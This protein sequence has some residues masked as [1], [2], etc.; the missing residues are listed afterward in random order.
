[1]TT[2]QLLQRLLRNTTQPEMSNA[3]MDLLLAC[4]EKT[5]E[6]LEEAAQI[7]APRYSTTELGFF[8]PEPVTVE[9]GATKGSTTITGTTFTEEQIG[10]TLALSPSN[11]GNQ[12]MAPTEL[13]M[14]VELETGT[15][16]ATLYYD[17]IRLHRSVIRLASD[18][19]I[20]SAYGKPSR[21]TRWEP[22]SRQ[23]PW[24]SYRAQD[25]YFFVVDPTTG[26]PI[27]YALYPGGDTYLRDGT[28]PKDLI[29][30]WP[31]PAVSYQVFVDAEFSPAEIG[32]SAF[33]SA[34]LDLPLNPRYHNYV[35]A[36][37]EAKMTSTRYFVMTQ[38]IVQ[39]L[40]MEAANARAQLSRAASDIGVSD[41]CIRTAPGY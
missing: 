3:P 28:T 37:A 39:R 31:L 5:N 30:I 15:Y 33:K 27:Y 6:A 40:D 17:A 16:S 2:L 1:M 10:C 22:N 4:A 20:Y 29:R 38:E 23:R 9:V 26:I 25:H 7:L 19:H 14:P 13:L 24:M 11:R 36:I 35:A 18:P 41:N 34:P 21:L 12:V 8:I 32:I